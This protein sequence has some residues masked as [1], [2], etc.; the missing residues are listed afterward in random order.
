MPAP[1]S[2]EEDLR[3][4]RSSIDADGRARAAEA[5]YLR[6]RNAVF[7][8]GVALARDRERGEELLQRTFLAFLESY[9]RYDPARGGLRPFL[10]GI[11]RNLWR[12]DLRDREARLRALEPGPAFPSARGGGAPERPDEAAANREALRRLRTA[13]ERLSPRDQE[14]VT[15]VKLS[16]LSSREAGGALGMRPE[17]VRKALVRALRRLRR[18]LSSL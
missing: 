13:L 5:L 10:L 9:H 3:L 8:L 11:C 17:A 1:E 4:L 14:L 16:G 15:L 7:R 6:H 12:E 2:D 18:E